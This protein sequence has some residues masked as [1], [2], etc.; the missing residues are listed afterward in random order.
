VVVSVPY[1]FDFIW[2]C[3]LTLC[4]VYFTSLGPNFSGCMLFSYEL[5]VKLCSD[6][7]TGK[8]GF[9]FIESLLI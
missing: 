9:I 7:D 3:N 5:S 6:C 2:L 8:K 4:F 1:A